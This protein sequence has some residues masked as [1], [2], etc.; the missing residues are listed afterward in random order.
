M[1]EQSC[2]YQPYWRTISY[3]Q[4]S[5]EQVEPCRMLPCKPNQSLTH[6]L[7]ISLPISL[8]QSLTNSPIT[9]HAPITVHSLTHR[10]LTHSLPYYSFT[11][12]SLS[13]SLSHSISHSLIAHLLTAHSLIH[14]L[15]HCYFTPSHYFLTSSLPHSLTI[16]T[17]YKQHKRGVST[18][19]NP[20][21]C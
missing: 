5:V 3:H 18:R 2:M 14:Y 1:P 6:S 13:H 12:Y 19:E 16:P 11:T 21:H 10:S 8:N 7:P 17:G 20:I 9:A 4:H 15:S